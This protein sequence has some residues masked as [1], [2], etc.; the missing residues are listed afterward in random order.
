MRPRSWFMP[1]MSRVRRSWLSR[2]AIFASPSQLEA[3]RLTSVMRSSSF[4]V[5]VLEVR[6][7]SAAACV[8]VS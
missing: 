8:T 3:T 2:Y 5:S 4:W 7:T 1:D 6:R